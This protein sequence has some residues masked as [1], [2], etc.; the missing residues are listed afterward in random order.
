M[1]TVAAPSGA[2]TPFAVGDVVELRAARVAVS[3]YAETVELRDARGDTLAMQFDAAAAPEGWSASERGEGAGCF[4][5]V[6][7]G[8]ACALV[9][10]RGWRRLETREGAF[11]IRA[12]CAGA[13]R[14]GDDKGP[15]HAPG[16]T[17]V[18][19]SRVK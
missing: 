8:G 15:G 16:P 3:V 12:R 18:E 7:H 17:S 9:G 11:A 10:E 19:V 6:R 2:A 14:V 5:V 1:V 4:V 13:P